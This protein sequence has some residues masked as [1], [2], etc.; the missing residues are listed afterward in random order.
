MKQNLFLNLFNF[1]ALIENIRTGFGFDTEDI[2]VV[3][4]KYC[5]FFIAD[6]FFDQH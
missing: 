5:I 6:K 4:L 1:Y 2:H 3:N